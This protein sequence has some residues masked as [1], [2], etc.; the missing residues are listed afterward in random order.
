MKKAII[1]ILSGVASL[2]LLAGCSLDEI[3]EKFVPQALGVGLYGDEDNIQ[4]QIDNFKNDIV[5]EHIFDI[6]MVKDNDSTVMVMS[7]ST[8]ESAQDQKLWNEVMEG[9]KTKPLKELPKAS[10][11]EAILFSKEKSTKLTLNDNSI[12]SKHAGN[13]VFGNSRAY[14]DHYL[15][16][17]DDQFKQL[18]GHKK[19]IGFLKFHEDENPKHKLNDFDDIDYVQLIDARK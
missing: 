13:I 5:D 16:V 1:L 12:S 2:F 19:A 8:A 15:I 10:K 9:D 18:T 4:M 7:Q 14:T 17:T 6:K 11:E 3:S